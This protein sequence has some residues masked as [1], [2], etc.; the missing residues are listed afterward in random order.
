MILFVC[1]SMHIR[2]LRFW[3]ETSRYVWRCAA[4]LNFLIEV[5]TNLALCRLYAPNMQSH[6]HSYPLRTKPRPDEQ[7]LGQHPMNPQESLI[8]L[9]SAGLPQPVER[10]KE[11]V[12]N[13][14]V[15]LFA[16]F[17]LSSPN[18]QKHHQEQFARTPITSASPE[19][20]RREVM[21]K[22]EMLD[23]EIHLPPPTDFIVSSSKS[24]STDTL[25]SHNTETS[26][27]D[28]SSIIGTD[29]GTASSTS[30]STSSSSSS[31]ESSE[32]SESTTTLANVLRF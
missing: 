22:I 1:A 24:S 15:M 9:N 3:R 11:N 13:N 7:S 10:E 8:S 17:S 28:E 23:A 21:R 27:S 26:S 4:K 12:L 16:H 29:S 20:Q 31:A 30:E 32:S 19:L 6:R 2:Q 14:D 25:N 5:L 18:K